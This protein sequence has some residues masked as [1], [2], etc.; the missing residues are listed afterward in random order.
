MR[1]G[2]FCEEPRLRLL[3]GLLQKRWLR[4]YPRRRLGARWAF[5]RSGMLWSHL[6]L[7]KTLLFVRPSQ[8]RSYRQE[9]LSHLLYQQDLGLLATHLPHGKA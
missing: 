8:E 5:P 9:W 4:I 6:R 3:Q 1:N 2:V 7:W